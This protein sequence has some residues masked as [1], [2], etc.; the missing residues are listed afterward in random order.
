MLQFI[1][2]FRIQCLDCMEMIHKNDF[3]KHK[4]QVHNFKRDF[5]CDVCGLELPNTKELKVH[6]KTHNTEDNPYTNKNFECFLCG[7]LLSNLF[8]LR[9]HRLS[10][11]PK[12]TAEKQYAK[13]INQTKTSTK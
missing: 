13:L 1:F 11:H 10:I 7:K 2:T 3:W 5:S 6:L 12:N 8:S 9:K 4:E